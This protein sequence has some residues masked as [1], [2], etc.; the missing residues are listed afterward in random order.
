MKEMHTLKFSSLFL[1]VTL[2][3]T[4]TGC[5]QSGALYL[6]EEQQPEQTEPQQNADPSTQPE[7]QQDQ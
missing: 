5:G 2:M 7:N 4:L 3:L 1:L 6:P